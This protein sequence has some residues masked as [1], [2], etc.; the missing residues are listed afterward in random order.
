MFISLC[1]NINASFVKHSTRIYVSGAKRFL[2]IGLGDDD[3]LF[4]D[5]FSAC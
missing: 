3:Q 1:F 4:E 5:D 2:P